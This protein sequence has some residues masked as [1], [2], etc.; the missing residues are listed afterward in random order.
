MVHPFISTRAFRPGNPYVITASVATHAGL[1]TLALLSPPR[2][3]PTAVAVARAVVEHVTYAV[4][5][6]LTGRVDAAGG[7]RARATAQGTRPA[8]HDPFAGLA[9]L[10][11][12]IPTGI[13]APGSMDAD[14]GAIARQGIAFSDSA[15]GELAQGVLGRGV[16]APDADGAYTETLVEKQV[17]P[18][19]DNPRPMYP[20]AFAELGL[21]DSFDVFFVVDSTGRVDRH[22][23]RFAGRVERL[24]VSAVRYALVRSRYFPAELGGRRV[25]QL[26]EQR[27]VFRMSP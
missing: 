6:P 17:K 2:A 8:A 27:F 9:S 18:F 11:L 16:P 26:V 10:Q 25:P 21:E 7:A 12:S 1:I 20:R 3:V 22:T 14:F 5:A 23:I 24:L 13:P 15:D 4:T 19:D